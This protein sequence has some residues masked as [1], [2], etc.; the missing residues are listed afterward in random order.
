MTDPA[1]V[2]TQ[3]TTYYYSVFDQDRSLLAPLY[4]CAVPKGVAISLTRGF[5]EGTLY[6]D[7]GRNSDSWHRTNP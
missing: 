5:S 3:F 2:G 7:L 1:A 4:V 6:D